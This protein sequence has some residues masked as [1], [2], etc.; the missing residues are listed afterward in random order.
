MVWRA[1][2][3][4]LSSSRVLVEKHELKLLLVRVLSLSH[5]CVMNCFCFFLFY[6]KGTV[7]L[8]NQTTHRDPI[9]HPNHI[10]ATQ[11]TSPLSF[12]LY[13][14]FCQECPFLLPSTCSSFRLSHL[15]GFTWTP[16]VRP[17][18]FIT[19]NHFHI[20]FPLLDIKFK[21]TDSNHNCGL[22]SWCYHFLDV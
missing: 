6:T 17:E 21:C 15:R 2:G 19:R 1:T 12:C 7:C 3:P 14:S 18:L 13:S 16:Y 4:T 9:G 11:N 10:L 5:I 22:E 20:L 8:S